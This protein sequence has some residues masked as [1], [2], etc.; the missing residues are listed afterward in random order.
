[1]KDK[2]YEDI[3]NKEKIIITLFGAVSAFIL[4]GIC[5]HLGVFE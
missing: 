4:I 2:D 1:M 3:T 5:M